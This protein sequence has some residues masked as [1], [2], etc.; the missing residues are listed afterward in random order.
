MAAPNADASLRDVVGPSLLSRVSSR[1]LKGTVEETHSK[2]CMDP[3]SLVRKGKFGDIQLFDSTLDQHIG[4][5][6]ARPLRAMYA[7]HVMAP[8]SQE[9][10]SPP[11]HPGLIC[12]PEGE[13]NFVVGEDGVDTE[14]WELKP[15]ARPTCAAGSMVPGRNDA[16]LEDLLKMPQVL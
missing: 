4:F 7:E 16:A 5:M 2:L 11:N 12:T 9:P 10:F 15:G 3:N 8:G 14:K 6:D 13:F 1:N